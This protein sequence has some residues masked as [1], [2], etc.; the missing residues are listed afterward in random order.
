MPSDREPLEP[1]TKDL[2]DRAAAGDTAAFGLVYQQ[3]RHLVY[4]FSMAMTGSRETAEDVAQEV[5]VTLFRDFSRYD[6]SRASFTTYLYGIARNLSRERLR[7][8]RRFLSLAAITLG[9]RESVEADPFD[10]IDGAQEAAGMRE[11]LR[12]LPTRYRELIV[13]CDLHGLS[14]ADSAKVVRSSV[15]AVRSRL[16][17]GRNLLREEWSRVMETSPSQ[18]MAT[19]RCAYDV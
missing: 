3:Y 1:P 17:R 12:R 18:A 16:H 13:L 8:D 2:L 11:A 15:P 19:K 5:F 9:A 6:A 14:Y 4:R 7:R 10:A